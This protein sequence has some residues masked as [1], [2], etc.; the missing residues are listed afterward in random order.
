M[1]SRGFMRSSDWRID[2]G[3]SHDND[4]NGGCSTSRFHSYYTH[5]YYNILCEV[6]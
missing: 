1:N 4:N 3:R 5:S 6:L 2:D